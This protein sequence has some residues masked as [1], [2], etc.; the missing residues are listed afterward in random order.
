VKV[1]EHGQELNQK[2]ENASALSSS[3]GTYLVLLGD[4]LSPKSKVGSFFVLLGDIL[5]PNHL[6]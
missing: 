6:M 3:V 2:K 1:L 5:S 4:T